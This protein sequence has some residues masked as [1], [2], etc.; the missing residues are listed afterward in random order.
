MLDF[1]TCGLMILVLGCLVG[2]L[3]GYVLWFGV[4]TCFL[5]FWSIGCLVTVD[6]VCCLLFGIVCLM[7]LLIGCCTTSGCLVCFVVCLLAGYDM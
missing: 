6:F 5:G 7:L 2:L 3:F 1:G 4:M